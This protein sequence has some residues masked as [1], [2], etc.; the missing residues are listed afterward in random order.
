MGPKVEA[1][2]RFARNTG[3]PASIG[4]LDDARRVLAG[5]AGTR[6]STG[7]DGIAYWPGGGVSKIER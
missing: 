6:V 3:M 2:V 1:A 5:R 7:W 4:S